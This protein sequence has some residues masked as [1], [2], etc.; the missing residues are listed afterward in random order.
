MIG[1]CWLPRC[2]SLFWMSFG[3]RT[4]SCLSQHL[5]A[6]VRSLGR[7]LAQALFTLVCLPY[8]AFFSLDAIARTVGRMLVTRKRLLEWTP[9]DD[10]DRE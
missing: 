6:A 4:T 7:H 9:S 10:P 8:E 5:A 1:I 3:S 2:W